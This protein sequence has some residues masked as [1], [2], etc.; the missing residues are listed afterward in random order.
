MSEHRE[1]EENFISPKPADVIP[2]NIPSIPV[3]NTVHNYG[4]PCMKE[5]FISPKPA[6]VI[7]PN[8]PSIPVTNTV[9][10]YGRPC[11]ENFQPDQRRTTEV[12]DE[13]YT[14]LQ[15]V[16]DPM[17]TW[18]APNESGWVNTSCGY[19]PEQVFES[20]L[21]SNFAAGNCEQDPNLRR[22]NENLFTQ[23]I[24]PGVYTRSQVNEPINSNIGISFQQ[25]F[26]PLTCK[27][28]DSGLHYL[29]HDPRIIEPAIYEPNMALVDEVNEANVYDPRFYGYGTSYRSY[30]DPL[31]GQTRFAY[32]DINA[33]RMPNYITRSKIDFLPYADQYGPMKPGQEDGNPLTGDIRGLA[34]TSTGNVAWL[35]RTLWEAIVVDAAR[36]LVCNSILDRVLN[37]SSS[38][39]A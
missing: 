19:N 34:T 9:N 11:K 1:T 12:K 31:L 20:D 23:T 25:Q 2:P 7:P 35:P 4:R 38:R 39:T 5:G 17:K 6:D 13:K 32:D 24:Q 37:S 15:T 18:I 36:L 26:Q 22:F 30:S 14:T 16:E 28:N 27:R 10:N 29:N 8:I 3:T 33:I 21:P